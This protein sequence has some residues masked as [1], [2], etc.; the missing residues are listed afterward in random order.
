MKYK[1]TQNT[2][3]INDVVLYQIQALKDGG[4]ARH[5]SLTINKGG[6]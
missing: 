6:E 1:L 2:K 5:S 4:Q 3:K